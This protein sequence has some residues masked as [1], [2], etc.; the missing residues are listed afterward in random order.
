[1]LYIIATVY[2]YGYRI[3][4]TDD[5]MVE[6]VSRQDAELLCKQGEVINAKYSESGK[7][8]VGVDG[9]TPISRLPVTT[10]DGMVQGRRGIAV[11]RIVTENDAPIGV[12]CCDCFGKMKAYTFRNFA[13]ISRKYIA[14]NF[15]L[16]HGIDA[17]PV[18]GEDFLVIEKG[19]VGGTGGGFRGAEGGIADEKAT[20]YTVTD[21]A[22][23]GDFDSRS[24]QAAL[25]DAVLNLKKVSPYYWV[26]Y[27]T[28]L[29]QPSLGI[30][31][32]AV[33]EDRMLYNPEFLLSLTV[34][35][36]TFVIMHEI[37]HLGM[38][39]S[40]RRGN[41]DPK[42]W[43]TATDLYINANICD[44]FGL[45]VGLETLV[46]DGKLEPL[47]GGL[48][49]V[50]EGMTLD[51]S[52]ETPESIY[53]KLEKNSQGGGGGE[54]SSRGGGSSN[55]GDPLNG[56]SFDDLKGKSFD[57]IGTNNDGE[58]AQM[59]SKEQSQGMSQRMN[60][61]KKM[62]E[63]KLGTPLEAGKGIGVLQREIEF[64]LSSLVDWR[65]VLQKMAKVARKKVYTLN[66]PNRT[67]M[68]AGMTV[69]GRQ[70]VGKDVAIQDI[71][72]CIDVSGSISD[73]DL[74]WFLSEVANIFTRFDA[75]GELIYWSTMVGDVCNFCKVSDIRIAKP[76]STGGTDVSCLFRY[77]N[78]EEETMTNK[79][80]KSSIRDIAGVVIITDG[81]FSNNYAE[82][83]RAFGRKTMWL[84]TTRN[85]NFK[86]CFG[87]V[88]VMNS[89]EER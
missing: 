58:N 61:K 79:K 77:L 27:G 20:V 3:L 33:T 63:E 45:T 52:K 13:R 48:Y 22:D 15:R 84:L 24:C 28:V 74:K 42:K 23:T 4:D 76:M 89:K 78:G 54:G 51:L 37:N 29:V 18:C 85:I 53:D 44:E 41:R 10:R 56:K 36:L 5:L 60:T 80:E 16:T 2:D 71:K 75:S 9:A 64:N 40:V 50:E 57:D 43:N 62:M 11:V 35:Q 65:L 25:F 30:K 88:S 82:Y 86:P 83:E 55:K 17:V 31:T 7:G 47:K 32:L 8:I 34:P 68:N 69:A 6:T 39:H 49:P 19:V 67:Y 81:Y 26:L 70:K 21:V 38:Q 46:N 72:I 66:K 87:R 1:M 14:C 59:D 12:L 73:E